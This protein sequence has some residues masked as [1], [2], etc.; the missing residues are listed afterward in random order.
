L[1]SLSSTT[2]SKKRD[3]LTLDGFSHL[4]D[5]IESKIKCLPAGE[6]IDCYVE[7]EDG[8]LL[9]N[10]VYQEIIKLVL[11][12][13]DYC[14]FAYQIIFALVYCNCLMHRCVPVCMQ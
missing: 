2:V 8:S 14:D 9:P 7:E 10:G 13:S 12:N 3:G 6:P 4:L 11:W 5:A 1:L